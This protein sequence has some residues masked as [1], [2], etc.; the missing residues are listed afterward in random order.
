[1][2]PRYYATAEVWISDIE[3]EGG[4]TARPTAPTDRR[5]P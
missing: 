3:S 5:T 2:L 4:A 1:M